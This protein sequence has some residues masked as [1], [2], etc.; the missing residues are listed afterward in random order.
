MEERFV[1]ER[2]RPVPGAIDSRGVAEGEP[3]LPRRFL[4]RDA[5]HE[6]EQVL[7]RW[8]ET[9]ACTHGSPERYVRRHW[10]RVRTAAGLGMRIYCDRNSQ[11]KRE[12]KSRWWLYTVRPNEEDKP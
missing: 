10:F 7:D 5:E 9:S 12:A 3:G 2:I 8:K 6:I 1:G 4:W 11:S